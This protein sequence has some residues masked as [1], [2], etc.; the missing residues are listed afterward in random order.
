[1]V[2]VLIN[3]QKKKCQQKW[4][5]SDS[6][7]IRVFYQGWLDSVEGDLYQLKQA[8]KTKD[9]QLLGETMERNGL[10]CMERLAASL[11]SLTGL[12]TAKAMDAVRQLKKA[13]HATLMD[14][15]PNVKV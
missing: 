1:M 14:A 5:A 4:D 12:L 8:I 6:R 11:H 15:G 2:F 7:N 13:F 10:K 3:D 9:F